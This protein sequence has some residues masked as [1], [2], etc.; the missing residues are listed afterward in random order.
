MSKAIIIIAFLIL[1]ILAFSYIQHRRWE[2]QLQEI[3]LSRP[4]LNR[5]EYIERMVEK[6]FDR[7]HA[8]VVYDEV[9]E[10]VALDNFSLYPEDDIHKLY[11]IEDLDEIDLI[12]R[13]C[14]RLDL[15]KV[16]QKDCDVVNKLFETTTAE[17]ILTLTKKLEREKKVGKG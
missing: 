3:N 4:K 2:K 10:F 9:K 6:G 1:L 11:G 13:I 17:Y 7:K 12:D 14:E 5:S 16:E 15:R 8:E